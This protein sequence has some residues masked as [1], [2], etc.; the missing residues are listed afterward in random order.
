MEIRETSQAI[1]EAAAKWAVRMSDAPLTVADQ[2]ELETWLKN[3]T[4]R[5]GAL[6][7]ARAV[8]AHV[9]RAKALGPDF[10]GGGFAATPSD[11]V[12]DAD[13]RRLLLIGGGAA[14]AGV[15]LVAGLGL[16]PRYTEYA[17]KRGEV[18]LV[19]LTDGSS[20][21]LN[22]ASRIAVAFNATKRVVRLLE[23]EA[24]FDVIPD[25]A[26]PFVVDAGDAQIVAPAASF[27]VSR[28]LKRA[29]KVLVRNGEVELKR[30]PVITA[31]PV[32][33]TANT[34]AVALDDA[35]VEAVS[36]APSQVERDLAWREGMLS[37]EDMRLDQA[38]AE[39]LRY[40][41]THIVIDDPSIAAETVTGLFSAND[42]E[43]FTRAVA[44]TMN[45]HAWRSGRELHLSH[46]S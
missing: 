16:M 39:F 5:V 24:L 31:R 12:P 23:G 28:L 19:P 6:A 4:R 17:T 26:R 15:V 13:R 29:V 18:R 27:T 1:D 11:H 21:T 14:A 34:S 45:L 33:L 37:F 8:I 25:A 46:Q 3:D 38:A 2:A 9:H 36:I 43:G 44:S 20:V 42:P 10:D 35:P 22:T 30:G 32:R 40:S 7:K 41:D